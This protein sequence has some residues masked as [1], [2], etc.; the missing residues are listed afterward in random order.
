M[1]ASLYHSEDKIIK[2]FYFARYD[3]AMAITRDKGKPS[4]D[5]PS[6]RASH[7]K[8][9]TKLKMKSK[10]PANTTTVTSKSDTSNN[11]QT[12]SITINNPA[13][14][15]KDATAVKTQTDIEKA[16]EQLKIAFKEFNDLLAK[17]ESL[18]LT[19]PDDIKKISI[20]KGDV[21]TVEK[22]NK[23]ILDLK[24]RSTKLTQMMGNASGSLANSTYGRTSTTA[25][26]AG[27]FGAASPYSFG[28]SRSAYGIT[29]AQRAGS[30]PT[31]AYSSDYVQQPMSYYSPAQGALTSN[32]Q[33]EM[34]ARLERERLARIAA[35][36]H[37]ALT[38]GAINTQLADLENQTH[39]QTHPTGGLTLTPVGQ[40]DTIITPETTLTQLELEAQEQAN[41]PSGGNTTVGEGV[42]NLQDPD[43]S[44]A[45][46][47]RVR[48]SQGAIEEIIVKHSG[49]AEG[50][51]LAYAEHVNDFENYT[52]TLT[53]PKEI[54]IGTHMVA[55]YRKVLSQLGEMIPPALVNSTG[56]SAGEEEEIDG[57]ATGVTVVDIVGTRPPTYPLYPNENA[58]NYPQLLLAFKKD[59]RGYRHDMFNFMLSDNWQNMSDL[60][61][62]AYLIQMNVASKDL[63]E[64]AIRQVDYDF[65]NNKTAPQLKAILKALGSQTLIGSGSIPKDKLINGILKLLIEKQASSDVTL[66]PTVI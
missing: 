53:N 14:S 57:D 65:L 22:I 13:S 18:K 58:E 19:I 25:R 5:T 31:N 6:G 15:T 45:F 61:K 50:L 42:I 2:A 54:A 20:E 60:E 34:M 30:F 10:S 3:K 40:L 56:G 47:E 21:D 23:L 1:L 59:V 8:P 51:Q 33:V 7:K 43:L 24:T 32:Y 36:Q 44:D 17:A 37:P 66:Q 12:V 26:T 62:G 29:Q 9:S 52:K 16:G 27:A 38:D 49:S 39:T 64:N 28:S 4:K 35:Q 41:Q 11:K 46:R 48:G 63:N 55:T